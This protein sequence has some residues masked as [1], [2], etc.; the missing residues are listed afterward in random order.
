MCL[1]ANKRIL[2]FPHLSRYKRILIRD[3]TV[4][5]IKREH[6]QS[7][8]GKYG[9]LCRRCGRNSGSQLT[10]HFETFLPTSVCI[11][12]K[13]NIFIQ[14]NSHYYISQLLRIFSIA[15]RNSNPSP[16]HNWILLTRYL[17]KFPIFHCSRYNNLLFDNFN[18]RISR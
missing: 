16:S 13:L 6:A 9:G 15:K 11:I 4:K 18:K 10:F 12:V 1:H 2:S 17:I 3:C 7:G 8:A 5:G 14:V